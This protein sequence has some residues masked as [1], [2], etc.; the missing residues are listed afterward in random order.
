VSALRDFAGP[1]A[2][3]LLPILETGGSAGGFS[4]NDIP[5]PFV[6]AFLN[7]L[8]VA[9]LVATALIVLAGVAAALVREPAPLDDEVETLS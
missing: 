9:L 7:G 8:Q 6:T 2:G 4:L 5:A 3:A 1:F